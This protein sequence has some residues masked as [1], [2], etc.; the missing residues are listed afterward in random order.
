MR[1]IYLTLF[2]LVLWGCTTVEKTI[3]PVNKPMPTKPS[4]KNP[5]NV[6]LFTNGKKPTAPFKI[7][8]TETV[9]KYNFV[10]IKRQEAHI[11]DVMRNLAANLG[12]DAV[13]NI[14]HQ[15][16]NIVGTVIALE[17]GNKNKV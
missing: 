8:G 2:C 15:D 6:T 1:M 5:M 10:G 11:R 3:P 7:I 13:I 9:S 14:S 17:E 16:K 12:G 4:Q